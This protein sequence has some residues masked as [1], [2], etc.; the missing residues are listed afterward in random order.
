MRLYF[1]QS[2]KLGTRSFVRNGMLVALTIIAIVGVQMVFMAGLFGKTLFGYAL[3]AVER[4]VDVRLSLVADAPDA[5]TAR[6]VETV[7]SMPHVVEVRQEVSDSIYESFKQRH[8]EDFLTLQALQELQGNPFGDEIIIKL[9]SASYYNAF[10][11][12]LENPDIF[13]SEILSIIEDVDTERNDEMVR[14]L[15]NFE[16][17]VSNIGLVLLAVSFFIIILILSVVSR[18][19]L[20]QYSSDVSV[21]R[22]YGVSESHIGAWL[23]VTYTLCIIFATAISVLCVAWVFTMFDAYVQS[24]SAGLSLTTWF[25]ANLWGI[26]GFV[27]FVSLAIVHAV[28]LV[29]LMVRASTRK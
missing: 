10:L 21:M 23:G 7:K 12:E 25:Q 1:V 28:T 6:L 29:F 5:T 18:L 9:D 13:N 26:A 4:R 3:S 8:A 19:F 20:S 24:L 27:F 15:V 2:L 11:A 17:T 22:N 14:R 16:Q